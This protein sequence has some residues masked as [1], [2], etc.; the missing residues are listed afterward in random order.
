MGN[1]WAYVVYYWF[2]FLPTFYKSDFAVPIW[3]T[4]LH[5][6]EAFKFCMN[7]FDQKLTQKMYFVWPVYTYC[8]GD[9]QSSC[10]A[11]H[12]LNILKGDYRNVEF[13]IFI[14]CFESFLSL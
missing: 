2:S 4:N 7:H 1:D 9:K 8:H 3:K 5:H 10:C 14:F 11:L 12:M 6:S 13:R